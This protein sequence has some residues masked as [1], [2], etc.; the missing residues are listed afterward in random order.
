M[1]DDERKRNPA[2]GG[3][4]NDYVLG[5]LE[6]HGNFVGFG[7]E[8]PQLTIALPQWGR[9]A[10]LDTVLWHFRG[11]LDVLEADVRRLRERAGLPKLSQVPPLPK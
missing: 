7:Y 8:P 6:V 5:N 2:V 3:G 1:T 11:R 4:A 10:T 9:D